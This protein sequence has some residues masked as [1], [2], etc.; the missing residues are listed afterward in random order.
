ML[1]FTHQRC[2]LSWAVKLNLISRSSLASDNKQLISCEQILGSYP[3][4]ISRPLESSLSLDTNSLLHKTSWRTVRWFSTVRNHWHHFSNFCINQHTYNK[5]PLKLRLEV[6]R[7][8]ASFGR[9]FWCWWRMLVKNL[10][11]RKT[12]IGAPWCWWKECWWRSMLVKKYYINS[13]PVIR[14]GRGPVRMLIKNQIFEKTDHTAWT[15]GKD[16]QG[17]KHEATITYKQGATEGSLSPE[18][19]SQ[20]SVTSET[21]SYAYCII[22]TQGVFF[23]SDT[24]ITIEAVGL[25]SGSNDNVIDGLTKIKNY[26]VTRQDYNTNVY[27]VYCI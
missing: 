5:L 1:I 6:L 27:L 20:R 21:Y 13:N 8:F 25:L 3:P 9:L 11:W 4:R 16:T 17:F 26:L 12:G 24:E 19:M 22:L 7:A 15:T 2:S 23:F 14:F 18:K 10:C